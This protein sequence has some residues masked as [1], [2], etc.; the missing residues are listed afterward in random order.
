M[1]CL[2]NADVTSTPFVGTDP[3]LMLPA[4]SDEGQL[5]SICLLQSK[6]KA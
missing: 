2:V 3:Q 1:S 5:I 6:N 4:C